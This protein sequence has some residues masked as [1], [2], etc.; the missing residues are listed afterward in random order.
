MIEVFSFVFPTIT[1]C[2]LVVFGNGNS[3]GRGEMGHSGN[4]AAAAGA[5]LCEIIGKQKLAGKLFLLM[6]D[7]WASAVFQFVLFT[8][9]R[10]VFHTL[11]H[12][13][14]CAT[15]VSSGRHT[16]AIASAGY[17]YFW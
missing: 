10:I 1:P 12:I 15:R 16:V 7:A 3:I 4:A 13:V 2:F 5:V 14:L 6:N 8:S 17:N 9:S 11:F